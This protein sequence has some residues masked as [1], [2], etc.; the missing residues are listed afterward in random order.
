MM[1]SCTT[2]L[3]NRTNKAESP[4]KWLSFEN[5]FHLFLPSHALWM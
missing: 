1:N 3:N 5:G 2:N 4:E